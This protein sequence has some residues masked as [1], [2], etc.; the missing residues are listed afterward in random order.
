MKIFTKLFIQ[1]I[2]FCLIGVVN[3]VFAQPQ[4][5][6]LTEKEVESIR[7]AKIKNQTQWVFTTN[8]VNSEEIKAKTLYREFNGNGNM[9]RQIIYS[10]DGSIISDAEYEY[11][12]NGRVIN[13]SKNETKVNAKNRYIYNT[14][15]KLERIDTYNESNE[16]AARMNL[17]Y[18]PNRSTY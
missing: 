4:S 14:D 2:I 11:D 5:P 12:N 17:S 1:T 8:I 3:L 15:N 7:E 9:T 6:T 10:P 18:D 16:L 13:S